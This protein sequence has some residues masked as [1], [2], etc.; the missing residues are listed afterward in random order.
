MDSR[1]RYDSKVKFQT[2]ADTQLTLVSRSTKLLVFF[3]TLHIGQVWT[4]CMMFLSMVKFLPG[5]DDLGG[6]FRQTSKSCI[7][8]YLD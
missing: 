8:I 5:S 4:K 7:M 1:P 6:H 2:S 3:W